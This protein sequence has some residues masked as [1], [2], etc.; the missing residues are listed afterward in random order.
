VAPGVYPGSPCVM[1][2]LSNNLAP[3]NVRAT[4]VGF[5]LP[6]PTVPHLWPL[7]RT[8]QRMRKSSSVGSP[9]NIPITSRLKYTLGH[10]INIGSL[11]CCILACTAG[12]LYCHWENGKRDRGER[13]A[14]LVEGNEAWLGYRHPHFRSTA[15][16]AAAILC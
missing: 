11:G 10:S 9:H 5:Q 7:S 6:L 14:R 3:H 16:Y 13:D 2:W 8:C 12:I 4:G 15:L 1:G